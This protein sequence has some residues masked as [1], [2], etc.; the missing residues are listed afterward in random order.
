MPRRA[1]GSGRGGRTREATCGTSSSSG[2]R[3]GGVRTIGS[4]GVRLLNLG[5][6]G[7]EHSVTCGREAPCPSRPVALPAGSAS[8]PPARERERSVRNP[9]TDPSR[10]WSSASA[11]SA[12]Q[13]GSD[14]GG[15][16][17]GR[18]GAP[19]RGRDADEALA[20]QPHRRAVL[21]PVGVLARDAAVVVD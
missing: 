7:G 10:W 18:E 16:A 17:A 6:P 19:A 14:V 2:E 5:R 21:L 9:P 4:A 11:R 13:T 20:L 12:V 3:G 8:A 15:E 1:P